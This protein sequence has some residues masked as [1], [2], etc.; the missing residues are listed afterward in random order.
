MRQ[1]TRLLTDPPPDSVESQTWRNTVGIV[2][3]EPLFIVSFCFSLDLFSRGGGKSTPQTSVINNVTSHPLWETTS[4]R[5]EVG[6][7]SVLPADCRG[8]KCSS[9]KNHRVVRVR[10]AQ[11]RKRHRPR[12]RSAALAVFFWM[13]AWRLSHPESETLLVSDDQ[14][15]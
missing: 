14:Q 15:H 10:S 3:V 11:P 2:K 5:S 1:R 9:R 12:A 8:R 4:T 13:K 7:Q 6:F